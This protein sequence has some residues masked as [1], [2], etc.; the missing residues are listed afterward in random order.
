MP[1][2]AATKERADLVAVQRGGMEL[3]IEPG[4][5]TRTAGS[6]PSRCL[7]VV[8][9]ALDVGELAAVRA[10]RIAADDWPALL[11]TLVA[12]SREAQFSRLTP[13]RSGIPDVRMHAARL[14]HLLFVRPR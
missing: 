12:W 10:D 5:R 8:A 11:A 13:C 1:G 7:D 2:P 9:E 6:G 14:P 4:R 3:I